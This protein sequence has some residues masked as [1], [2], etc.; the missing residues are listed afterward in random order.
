MDTGVFLPG[1]KRPRRE[2][3][4]SSPSCP[5]VKNEWRCTST[6]PIRLQDVDRGKLQVFFLVLATAGGEGLNVLITEEVKKKVLNRVH[7]SQDIKHSVANATMPVIIFHK[8]I[9]HFHCVTIPPALHCV[10]AVNKVT[11]Y[12]KMKR[13]NC[14]VSLLLGSRLMPQ[15][16]T[17][18]ADKQGTTSLSLR[19]YGIVT[20]QRVPDAG[21]T[22]AT[23]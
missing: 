18:R 10:I 4:H 20:I 22:D 19:K 12:R 15:V 23:A 16:A 3:N 1:L 14:Q 11:N 21:T 2:V 17:R 13:T 5:E 6:P 9:I 7:I 8:T